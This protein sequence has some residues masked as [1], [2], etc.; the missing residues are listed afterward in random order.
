MKF[1][2]GSSFDADAVVWNLDKLLNDKAPQFDPRQSAQGRS[3]I[4][5]GRLLPGDRRID[6]RDHHQRSG[7]DAALSTR[8]DHDVVARPVGEQSA[9]TGIIRQDAGGH[10]AVEGRRHSCRASAPSWCRT[11]PTG[12]RRACPS[13]T[14]W[15]CSRCPRRTRASPRCAP[16]RSTGS[17]R[18]RPTPFPR[19]R[20]AGFTIV[21]N[22]YP[23]NWTWHLSH[24]RGLAVERHPRAQGG[25]PRDR[26]RRPEGAARR[27][28]DPGARASIRRAISGSAIPTFEMT[29]TIPR[30]KK[31]L[32]EAGY[33]PNKPLKIKILISA[34]GSG[35]MQPLPMN[36]FVQQNLAEVGIK[37]EF[38]V[39]EWNTL[40]NF[41]RARRQARLDRA[42]RPASTSATSS[43]IR[44]PASSGTCS[45]ISP[46]P[47]APT[48]APTATPRWTSSWIEVAQRLRHGRADQRP[49]KVH[50]K[51]ST[52]PCS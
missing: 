45:A 18:R 17:R 27:H 22:A 42:A 36:E 3:R 6:A 41:W 49:A 5:G 25:Q 19:S 32:A 34:S 31:L 13:S 12:T 20:G 37:V 38:E 2:D 10:R 47:T 35:Q 40:I 23:H 28:D 15:C 29:R 48:G 1:H 9:A 46:R 50:E 52:R 16:A 33:G 30:R 43:R 4:P 51:S 44:S 21:T 39:I 7:R 8:L 26:P 24:G 11:R 14:R